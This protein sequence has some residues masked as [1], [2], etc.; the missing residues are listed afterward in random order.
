MLH[1]IQK[2]VLKELQEN[3]NSRSCLFTWE[4]LKLGSCTF[5][6]DK[7]CGNLVQF[8]QVVT[9]RGGVATPNMHD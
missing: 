3:L 8:E 4:H 9:V 6:R 5:E 7:G 2:Q 1:R